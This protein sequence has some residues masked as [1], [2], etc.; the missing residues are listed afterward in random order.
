MERCKILIR[1][2][3]FLLA[4]LMVAIAF[5]IIPG[6]Y[7]WYVKGYN[8]PSTNVAAATTDYFIEDMKVLYDNGMPYIYLKKAKGLDY[9]PVIFFALDGELEDYALHI[10]S[11]KLVDDVEI[12]IIPNINLSQAISLITWP[13][14]EVTGTLRIKHLNEFIDESLPISIPKEYLIERFIIDGGFSDMAYMSQGEKDEIFRLLK[15]VVIYTDR[16]M[17]WDPVTWHENNYDV[18]ENR[19]SHIPISKAEVSYEQES[20]IDIIA[21]NLLA[22]NRRLYTV[23][24]DIF[25]DLIIEKIK[26]ME[27]EKTNKEL[28]SNISQ[29]ED[30]IDRLNSK[31]AELEEDRYRLNERIGILETEKEKL[32]EQLMEIE[33]GKGQSDEQDTDLEQPIE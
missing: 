16:Y 11:V 23:M 26:N 15:E 14:K 29:L 25:D 32:E 19:F 1:A 27:L 33:S 28:L 10:D 22:Y 3:G 2:L 4:G 17:D 30:T 7:S 13:H 9:S 18:E 20:L 12:P 31:I 6:T 21:P 8:G 5:T 24:E